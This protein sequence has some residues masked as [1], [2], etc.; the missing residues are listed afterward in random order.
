MDLDSTSYI[1]GEGSMKLEKSDFG[2]G[3]GYES[4]TYRSANKSYR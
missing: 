4:S 3:G 2:L 1:F